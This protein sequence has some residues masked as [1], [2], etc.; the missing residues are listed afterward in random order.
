M[1]YRKRLFQ[2]FYAVAC[3]PYQLCSQVFLQPVS[4]KNSR[5]VATVA[6]HKIMTDLS[7]A[8]PDPCIRIRVW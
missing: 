2:S 8:L 5:Q 6:D 7:L 4:I 1:Q 3:R